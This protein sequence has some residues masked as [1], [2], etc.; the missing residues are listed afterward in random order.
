MDNLKPKVVKWPF[1]RVEIQAYEFSKD[2]PVGTVLVERTMARVIDI[3]DQVVYEAV[4]RAACE[5]GI[6]NV[7]LMDKQFVFDALR[8]KLERDYYGKIT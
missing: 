2:D 7:Y 6:D 3:R 5:A 8:E 4:I 1:Q